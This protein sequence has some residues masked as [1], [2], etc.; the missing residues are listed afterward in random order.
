MVFGVAS[1]QIVRTKSIFIFV[2]VADRLLYTHYR[3]TRKKKQRAIASIHFNSHSMRADIAVSFRR[4]HGS[5]A[6]L[7]I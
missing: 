4:S 5:L 1:M 6:Y 3:K 2:C 7:R